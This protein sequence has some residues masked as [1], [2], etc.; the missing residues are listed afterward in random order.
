MGTEGKKYCPVRVKEASRGNA[1]KLVQGSSKP[2]L[3]Q[4][5]ADWC[6][7][8]HETRPAV[9]KASQQLCGEV[10]VVRVNVERHSDLADKMGIRGLPTMLLVHNGKVVARGV[11][12]EDVQGVVKIAKR[13]L[14]K[15]ET[16]KG[17]GAKPR[18]KRASRAR[19]A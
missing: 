13:G 14:K 3:I 10:D 5:Y 16:A 9:D 15:I 4:F 2:T 6:G 12:S 11:G 19:K 1:V 18:A 7:A 8:C 17:G